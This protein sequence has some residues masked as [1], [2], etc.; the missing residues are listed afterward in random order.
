MAGHECLNLDVI[1]RLLADYSAQSLVMG[2]DRHAAVAMVL[3][4]TALHVELLLIERARRSDDPWSGQMA[5]PGGM[6]A[7]ADE[8][9]RAAAERETC[10]EIG[11]VL[12]S[13]HYLGR[14]DDM[15]GRHRG[16]P[17]G[18]IVSAFVYMMTDGF[19]PQLNHE[20]RDML[21]VPLP[22]FLDRVRVVQVRHPAAPG[23]FFPGIR[24]SEDSNQV[25]WGLT[26]RFLETFFRLIDIDFVSAR[27]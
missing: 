5:F 12:G 3:R 4:Q 14:I 22:V 21:W 25:V 24:V 19:T 15:Q 27:N 11:L 18:I 2:D 20:V 10:E 26:H 23:E 8:D 16:H 9:A 7:S 13:Q 6:V 17:A 1:R